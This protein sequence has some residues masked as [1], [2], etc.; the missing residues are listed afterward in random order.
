MTYHDNSQC[1]H[2]HQGKKENE[3]T[4][5]SRWAR[6]FLPLLGLG[7]LIWMLLRII[8]KPSRAEYPC[9]KVAAPLATGF[10][11]YTV[12]MSAALLSLKG[13]W[14]RFKDSKYLYAG[15]LGVTGIVLG[16]LAVLTPDTESYA[17]IAAVDSLFVP[18]DSPNSP[19][20]TARGIF[21]GRV[22]W[23]WDSTAT[24]WNGTNGNWYTDANTHQ[25]VVDSMMSQSLC[26][27]TGKN[28]DA[29]A[30]DAL[31]KFFNE[32]HGKGSVGYQQGEKIAIKI[33]QVTTSS[34]YYS[35]NAAF[36][37][38][39]TVLALT[40]ELVNSAGVRDSDITYFDTDRYIPDP[41]YSKVHTAF[42]GVHFVG[43][44]KLNGREQYVRDTTRVYWSKKLTLEINGGNPA[45]LPTVVTQAKYLINLA[46]FKAHRYMGI[47]FC[48]KNHF[49]TLSVSDSTGAPYQNAPHAA[50]LHVYTA[51]HDIYIAGS[52]EWTFTGNPMGSYNTL[53]DLMGHRDLGAKTLLFMIDGLYGVEQE[54]AEVST[55]SRWVSAPFNNHWTSSFFMSLDNVAI[56][57][58]GIDFF[59]TEQSRNKNYTYTYG[60][61]DNY[62]HEA[63]L[64]DN[65][66][67]GTFYHPNGDTIRLA[68]LGVHEH[69]NNAT[70]KQYSRSLGKGNGIELVSPQRVVASA[71]EQTRIA[72]FALLGNYPNPFN[73]TTVVSWQLPVVSNVKLEIMD[74][75]GRKV[76]TLVNE[77]QQPGS[78][79][80]LWNAAGMASGVYYYR[81][82]A[83]EHQ[84]TR[85]MMLLR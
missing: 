4:R 16:L 66:P 57:S 78:H 27:L 2:E 25:V 42:P 21:P 22:V 84:E 63:A 36:A 17:E 71:K 62:L 44:Q 32:H 34:Q 59:R 28:T 79:R 15:G 70:D 83:R 11:T 26:L 1:P 40:R 38:P 54:G 61:V 52:P 45:F 20:G 30:W 8:P 81:L 37:A 49:G 51:V 85:K 29:E 72:S 33:N 53:V 55:K 3:T 58:V 41:I 80:F 64:A 82:T 10:I 65:P 23:T 75:L 46:C 77:I 9:M 60:S 74:V 68:S 6:V 39:Q 69:W 76:A 12:G 47:T 35:P 13:A 73:P 48:S 18:I 7:S 24:T 14:S 56:E 31:F 67:S 5:V 19:V 43:W 50:G